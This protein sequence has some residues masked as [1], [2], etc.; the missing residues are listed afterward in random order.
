MTGQGAGADITAR[1]A[2]VRDADDLARL[3]AASVAANEAPWS[4]LDFHQLLMEPHNRGLIAFDRDGRACGMLIWRQVL[5]TADILALAV[6][7]AAR[8]RG[9]ARALLTLMING[10]RLAGGQTVMLE[11]ATSNAAAIQLYASLDFQPVGQR[12]GY[13][14]RQDGDREDARV[15]SLKL[16]NK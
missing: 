14:R 12:R 6:D 8:R 3:H 2:T 4:S 15:M 1:P 11:V 16:C 5:E 9:I 13:Y 10:I 7:P